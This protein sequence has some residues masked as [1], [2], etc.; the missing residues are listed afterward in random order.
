MITFFSISSVHPGSWRLRSDRHERRRKHPIGQSEADPRSEPLRKPV[1]SASDVEL[2]QEPLVCNSELHQR[3][4]TAAAQQS[5]G[6]THTPI[7]TYTQLHTLTHNYT[8]TQYDGHKRTERD[9][10]HRARECQ[11]FPAN[12]QSR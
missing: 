11:V 1:R 6:Y 2:Q 10:T 5:D 9:I 7:H 3:A 4:E 12:T 8:H